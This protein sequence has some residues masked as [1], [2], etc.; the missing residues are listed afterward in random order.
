MKWLIGF[1]VGILLC[2][3]AQ[4]A[5]Y[6]VKPTCLPSTGAASSPGSSLSVTYNQQC[7]CVKWQCPVPADPLKVQ[8]VI[9]CGTWLE[10]A[11]ASSRIST[12]QKATDPLKSLQ[13]AGKR[14]TIKPLSDPQFDVCPK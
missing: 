2:G 6:L 9:Y 1:I 5:P 14:F 12:I 4:S 11:K 7:V 13:D 10:A 3:T 8:Q